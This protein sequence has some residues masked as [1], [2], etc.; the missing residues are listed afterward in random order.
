MKG[1]LLK[2]WYMIASYCRRYLF[3]PVIFAAMIF[4]GENNLFFLFYLLSV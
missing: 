2:D 4:L 3:I 1:L